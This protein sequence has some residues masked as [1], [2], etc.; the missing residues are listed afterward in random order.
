VLPDNIQQETCFYYSHILHFD[1]WMF[2]VVHAGH[3]DIRN[4]F[5]EIL[6]V[7]V[8]DN[9]SFSFPQKQQNSYDT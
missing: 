5:A 9:R 8:T 1:E 3:V 2:H 4:D 6:L 7:I